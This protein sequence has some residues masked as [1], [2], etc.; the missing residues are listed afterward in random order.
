MSSR[1]RKTWRGK[2]SSKVNIYI[3]VYGSMQF[4][5]VVHPTGSRRENW[6]Y[7]SFEAWPGERNRLLKSF[8]TVQFALTNTRIYQL[9]RLLLWSHTAAAVTAG[10]SC[11]TAFS[12]SFS[13]FFSPFAIFQKG[14]FLFFSVSCTRVF[15]DIGGYKIFNDNKRPPT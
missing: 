11:R 2:P 5:E 12:L 7:F 9:V 13:L 3:H 1:W 10:F 6:F 4:L 8:F 14:F 15:L